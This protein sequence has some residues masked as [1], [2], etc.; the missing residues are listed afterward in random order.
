MEGG[1]FSAPPPLPPPSVPPPPPPE[2]AVASMPR[3]SSATRKSVCIDPPGPSFAGEQ[4]YVL[5]GILWRLTCRL[6]MTS[7]LGDEPALRDSI[8]KN[9]FAQRRELLCHSVGTHGRT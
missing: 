4:T 9:F 8:S 6:P 3:H 2:H 1:R 7:R 5:V